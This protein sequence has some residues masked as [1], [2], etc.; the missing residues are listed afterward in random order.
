VVPPMARYLG[1]TTYRWAPRVSRMSPSPAAATATATA[2]ATSA[3]ARPFLIAPARG[4]NAQISR[5]VTRAIK[6][7]SGQASAALG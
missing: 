1:H 3:A 7:G 5:L 2:T 4:V 6:T